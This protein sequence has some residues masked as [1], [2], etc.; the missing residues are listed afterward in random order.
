MIRATVA[1]LVLLAARA[2]ADDGPS[3]VSLA[4]LDAYRAALA[5]RA[6]DRAAPV[7]FRD[8]WEHPEKF[9]GR[10]VRVEGKLA[11]R[12][13]QDRVGEFPAL[14]EAWVVNPA[15]DPTCLV[16]PDGPGRLGIEVGAEVRFSGT[17]LR[18]IRYRGGDEARLAPLVVGP[19]PPVAVVRAVED[20]RWPGSAIDWTFGLGGSALILLFL[21]R[22][23]LARPD[24][25]PLTLDPPPRFLDGDDAHGADHGDD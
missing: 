1:T 8:L 2:V 4:D 17:F 18:K 7:T 21:L 5:S 23:H 25:R 22:R 10:P 13:R 15:G 19:S 6:D 9:A 14:V 12:F 16:Y 20:L 11:R 3:P 24:P